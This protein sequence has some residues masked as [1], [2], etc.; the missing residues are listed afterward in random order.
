MTERSM[1]PSIRLTL[2]M[3]LCLAGPAWSDTDPVAHLLA[4]DMAPEGVVFEIVSADGDYLETTLPL[5]QDAARRLRD[6]FP[7]LDVVV[8]THG[9]EQFALLSSAADESPQVHAK[10]RSLLDEDVRV[11]VCGTHASWYGHTPRD[12]PD[13]IDVAEA[14]PAQIND[15]RT[16]GYEL[17]VLDP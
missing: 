11:H 17:V 10:V 9:R 14:A 12:F 16:L 15:Y 4:R 5:A 3:I 1:H 8:V 6:R 13:Y 7:G 2:L